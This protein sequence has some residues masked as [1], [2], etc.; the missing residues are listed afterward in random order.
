MKMQKTNPAVTGLIKPIENALTDPNQQVNNTLIE[1]V[2]P[3]YDS[4]KNIQPRSKISFADLLALMQKPTIGEKNNAKALTPYN[5]N[6]KRLPDAQK[7]L[8]YAI[9]IDHDHD[10]L[11][12][13]ELKEKYD[14]FNIAYLAFTTSSH[15]QTEN[16][17]KVVIP[18]AEPVEHERFSTISNDVTFLMDADAAQSRTQQAF[19]AP[20]KISEQA[21][22]EYFERLESR[23]LDANSNNEKLI[24]D[25]KIA[26]QNATAKNATLKRTGVKKTQDGIIDLVNDAFDIEELIKNYGYKFKGGRYLS[27]CSQSG[28]PGVTVFTGVDGKSRLF[29][30]HGTSDPL[31]NL[32][33]EGHALDAFAVACC[34]EHN[35][36]VNKAIKDYANKLDPEGQKQRQ[37]DHMTQK[38]NDEAVTFFVDESLF[39]DEY[40][41]QE[42]AAPLPEHPKELI[43]LP[44]ALG[45]IQVFIYNRMTYPSMAGAALTALSVMTAF[46][47][48]HIT[49]DSRDGLGFNEWYMVLAPT[50][51]G[52]EDLRKPLGILKK[53]AEKKLLDGLFNN[54]GWRKA[55]LGNTENNE[56]SLA[57]A[58]PASAQGVHTLLEKNN[59]IFFLSDEFA[60]WLKASKEGHK[61]QALGYLMQS[62]SK[63]L[64]TIHPGNA[65]STAYED[66]ENP[67]LSVLA[68]S[69]SEAL[70]E[71]L[72]KEQAE[73][74]AYNRWV[75]FTGETTLPEKK[76]DGLIY[77]PED[78]LV[79]YIAWL[80]N[81]I[82]KVKF[83]RQGY[84]KYKELDQATAEKAK[85]N[86]ALLGGRLGEQAIKI[87]G[88]IAL[89]DKRFLIEHD[90]IEQAFKIR[91][92]IYK[93]TK[94]LSDLNGDLSGA[95]PT[96]MAYDQLVPFFKKKPHIYKSALHTYSRKYQSLPLRDQQH[97]VQMLIN[98]GIA[99]ECPKR[100]KIL[101]S[102]Y[103]DF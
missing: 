88:L 53:K 36:D 59:S 26:S 77:E 34:L 18:L 80:I 90:D 32:N 79:E 99:W 44:Y 69:T 30:H 78:N 27:P 19:Y 98:N 101:L 91:M 31:S 102:L 49:I 23:L 76:Y 92:G 62:Y 97:V 40:E 65:A 67:R 75:I 64:S 14:A 43:L 85:A 48:T 60:E 20:N 82:G 1:K 87:A 50:G 6:G 94:A 8:F 74:G 37:R 24:N 58:A 41:E 45:D 5:A 70:F 13:V 22:Y 55:Y 56:V 96:R 4:I 12:K 52:K 38:A 103:T 33:H 100:P 71:T 57:Y 83:S 11:H 21:P 2:L 28:I 35:G 68:T 47:Q 72:T 81:Q 51:F 9:V 95:H 17:W 46:A 61:Q 25:A 16:R 29:S 3:L 86:D 10:N 89:S 66:V 73:S 15:L 54:E 42:Q 63:A 84:S 7:A 39:E 93:R